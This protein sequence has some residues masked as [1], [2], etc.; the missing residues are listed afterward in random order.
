[1]ICD[2]TIVTGKYIFGY[3]YNFNEFVHSCVVLF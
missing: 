1:M 3:E 2:V